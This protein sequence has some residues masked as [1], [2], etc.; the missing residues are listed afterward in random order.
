MGIFDKDNGEIMENT[1]DTETA[2]T[3]VTETVEPAA[4]PGKPQETHVAQDAVSSDPE[5]DKKVIAAFELIAGKYGNYDN[6]SCK[7]LK[8]AGFDPEDIFE[9][10]DSIL[11][12]RE[13]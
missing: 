4:E 7:P 3:E 11:A 1:E 5:H 6:E 9:I 2:T 10:R 12:G 8:A 13:Y